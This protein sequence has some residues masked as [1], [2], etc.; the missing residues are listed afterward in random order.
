MICGDGGQ[1]TTITAEDSQSDDGGRSVT[2][3]DKPVVQKDTLPV[4]AISD[5]GGESADSD[6]CEASAAPK[7]QAN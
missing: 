3:T 2:V 4:R 5:S 7:K 6:A 1:S